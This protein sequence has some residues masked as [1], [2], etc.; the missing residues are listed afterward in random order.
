MQD[1]LKSGGGS[2]TNTDIDTL[3]DN[4]DIDVG[5]KAFLKLEMNM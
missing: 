5:L 4:L 1:Y 3:I 2:P